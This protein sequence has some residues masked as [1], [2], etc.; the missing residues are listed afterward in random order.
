MLNSIAVT[1][2]TR[3]TVTIEIPGDQAPKAFNHN[4][5]DT[6]PKREFWGLTKAELDTIKNEFVNSVEVP[7]EEV[8]KEATT[9]RDTL[10]KQLTN[11]ASFRGLFGLDG[12]S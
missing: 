10:R 6:L 4:T 7:A 11:L 12:E 5:G 8:S 2:V 3:N 9:I 1:K